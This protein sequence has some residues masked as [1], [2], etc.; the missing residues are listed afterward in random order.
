MM[1]LFK[2]NSLSFTFSFP[3][4]FL[5]VLFLVTSSCGVNRRLSSSQIATPLLSSTDYSSQAFQTS[6]VSIMNMVNDS[7][8]FEDHRDVECMGLIGCFFSWGVFGV[9]GE[10]AY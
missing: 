1:W 6:S 10:G 3:S 2:T 5:F 4:P 7:R 8:T 9:V